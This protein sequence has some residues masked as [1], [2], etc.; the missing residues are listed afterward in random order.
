MGACCSED[1]KDTGGEKKRN[2]F[3]NGGKSKA[4]E[5][6]QLKRNLNQVFDKYDSNHDGALEKT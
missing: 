3:Q 2:R 5:E 4:T 1:Q 6:N